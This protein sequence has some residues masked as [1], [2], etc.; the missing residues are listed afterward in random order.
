[1]SMSNFVFHNIIFSF[2]YNVV[3]KA[4]CG[5]RG[6]FREKILAILKSTLYIYIRLN[7]TNCTTKCTTFYG[8]RWKYYVFLRSPKAV[9]R[10]RFPQG[11]PTRNPLKF[12]HFEGFFFAIKFTEKVKKRD[13]IALFST[14]LCTTNCTTFLHLHRHASV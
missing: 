12:Q 9:V 11:S 1:M 2:L 5:Q 13:K 10:V 4:A 14:I 8:K 6:F 3:G 7:E